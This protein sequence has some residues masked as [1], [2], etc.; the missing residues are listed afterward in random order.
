L[1]LAEVRMSIEHGGKQG[2][3][4]EGA[5]MRA[6]I[7][8]RVVVAGCRAGERERTCRVFGIW[9]LSGEPPYLVRWDDCG[10]EEAFSPGPHACLV[11]V[12]QSG[13]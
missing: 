1:P 10:D 5:T 9:D 12:E 3:E 6:E 7:G 11:N 2:G 4:M 13:L 8:D